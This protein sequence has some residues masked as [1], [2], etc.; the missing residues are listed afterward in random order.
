MEKLYIHSGY[1]PVFLSKD[2]FPPFQVNS[3]KCYI[4]HTLPEYT[5]YCILLLTMYRAYFI[6]EYFH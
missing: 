4:L 6:I 5:I 1:K 3:Q 2:Y